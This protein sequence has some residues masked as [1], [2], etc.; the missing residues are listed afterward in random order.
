MRKR[1]AA[2]KLTNTIFFEKSVPLFW[3]DFGHAE[4]GRDIAHE[5]RARMGPS[6]AIAIPV[7]VV[8]LLSYITFAL[9]MAFFRATY[10][11][12]VGRPAVHH[13]HV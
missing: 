1:A 2:P 10:I 3:F 9:L 5:I 8:G 4:D 11:D 7:F 12:Y 6:L 13:R